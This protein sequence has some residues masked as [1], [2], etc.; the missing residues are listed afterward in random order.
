MSGHRISWLVLLLLLLGSAVRGDQTQEEKRAFD[1]AMKSFQG[2][3]WARAEQEWREFTIRF[4]VSPRVPEAVLYQ[5]QSL[6][7]LGNPAGAI[8]LLHDGFGQAG[9]WA[10]D[11]VFWMAESHFRAENYTAAAQGFERFLREFSHSRRALEASLGQ[12]VS[13]A[14]LQQWDKV[15]AILE[16]PQGALMTASGT[17]TNQVLLVRGHL[18]LAEAFLALGNY[19]AARTAIETPQLEHLDPGLEWQKQHLR[20]RTLQA[21]GRLPEALA[22][23]TNL[24]TAAR[25]PGQQ[26]LLAEA[27]FFQAQVLAEMG[28][29]DDAVTAYRQNL[30]TNI[31]PSI[32]VQTLLRLSELLIGS[33][34]FSEGR[35]IIEQFIQLSPDGAA[36]D[37]ARLT[38]AELKLRQHLQPASTPGSSESMPTNLLE[39]AIEDLDQVI[40]SGASG[41]VR[42]Q[43]Y[44]YR[45]WAEWI[46]GEYA[47][48]SEAF[49]QAYSTLPRSEDQV[50]AL[51]KWADAR[52]QLGDLDGAR[53]N[54]EAVVALAPGVGGR[55][56]ALVE[57][58]LY[59]ILRNG[60][61]LKRPELATRALGQLLASYPDGFLTGLGVLLTGQGVNELGD[62]AAA[63]SL[64][65]QFIEQAPDSP[66]A[67]EIQLGIARTFE[68]EGSW[69]HALA[70]YESILAS[71]VSEPVRARADYYRALAV[72]LSGQET[73]ALAYFT[74]FVAVYPTNALAPRAQWWIGD[75][76]WREADYINAELNYQLLFKNWPESDL[77]YEAR[78]M[79]GRAAMAR[80]SVSDA[81]GY[82]TNLTSDLSCPPDLKPKAMFA[83]GDALMRLPSA[84]TNDPFANYAEAIKVFSSVERNYP[85]NRL[86]ALA[87]GMMGGCYLQLAAAD[88][89]AFE[90]ASNAYQKVLLNPEAGVTER[91]QAEVG[92]A[93]A[94]E[95]LALRQEG[96][97][98]VR[99]LYVAL[100]HHL[101]V[102]YG[103]NLADGERPDVFW[104]KKAGLEAG[105][106]AETLQ[107]WPQALKLY[108]RLQGMIPSLEPLLQN[109]I[110][111]AQ[112]QAARART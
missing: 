10:E 86:A 103:K 13:R 29:V 61:E 38:I 32:Q 51:Y 60:L 95:K 33:E 4:P 92:L 48:S 88:P 43:A 100:D 14:R 3:F 64:L 20:A 52:F 67:G 62:P 5:A 57:P 98:R 6:I 7:E 2:E 54:Y 31:P 77:A 66:L 26:S 83:Y 55:A 79:A 46:R 16:D 96:A 40:Q 56:L 49:E 108:E 15:I 28:R 18:L 68:A 85:S 76:H 102:F 89:R 74:N 78:M 91:S 112:E 36:A 23:S 22:I 107:A 53:T 50:T 106:L 69:A 105:R 110:L 58:A 17:V 82:F 93:T 59:Q 71:T 99:L 75:Y 63:R 9:A 27:N 109:K 1:T 97:A 73:N 47:Q 25:G 87:Q 44:L 90:S 42:G 94:M 80:L 41:R 39:Q 34:R 37:L 30:S 45:G 35:G 21:L 24:I 70:Q 19:Q 84:S 12:A 81:I 72:A 111:K 11:Y 65:K 8:Q 101:N 104:V